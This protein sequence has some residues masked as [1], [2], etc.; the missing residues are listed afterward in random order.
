MG[1]FA[2]IGIGA[3]LLSGMSS[4]RAADRAAKAA[5]K[6]GEF[7]AKIIERDIDLLAKQR[8]IINDQRAVAKRRNFD[9][10]IRDVQGTARA[11][12]S[13]A[14]I[15][16]SQ[17]TPL[18]VLKANAREFEY[19]VAVNDFNNEVVNMQ[20]S[21]AQE[22]ARLNAKLSR[23]EAGMQAASARAQGTRSLISSIGSAATQAWEAGFIK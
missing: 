19:Q 17:G 6:A 1:L 16:I 2:A 12:Y 10:F 20:I 22:E 21:D 3:S 11:Q 15:D 23:M 18:E 5:K 9:Q 14:G 4:K 8:K 13:Y 7:N